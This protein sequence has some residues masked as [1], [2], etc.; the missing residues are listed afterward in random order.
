VSEETPPQ[1]PWKSRAA[2]EAY[3]QEFWEALKDAKHGRL[4]LWRKGVTPEQKVSATLWMSLFFP[5]VL[6]L[7]PF[8]IA[9]RVF[10]RLAVF[11]FEK[12]GRGS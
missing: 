1:A 2:W 4:H 3:K 8:K 10:R 9:Y 5:F 7:F 11:A 12:P 6:L